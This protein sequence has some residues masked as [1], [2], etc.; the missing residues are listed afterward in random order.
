MNMQKIEGYEFEGWYS[1][2]DELKSQSGVYV[3]ISMGSER[4]KILDVGE[5]S[6]VKDRIETHDKK[7]CWEKHS[8]SGKIQFG[9]LY[10]PDMD[11]DNREK[12]EAKIRNSPKRT[13]LCGK[14]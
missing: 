1:S 4:F 9:V 8:D 11:R 5:S 7:G 6:D 3:V 2:T 13:V 10:T 14:E 12:I